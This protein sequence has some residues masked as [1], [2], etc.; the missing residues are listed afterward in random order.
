MGRWQR[1]DLQHGARQ[2]VRTGLETGFE[3]V[4]TRGG[5]SF[6]QSTGGSW[7]FVTLD[8]QL[9][10]PPGDY[11]L[12]ADYISESPDLLRIGTPSSPL[13]L[14]LH[15]YVTFDSSRQSST[16]ASGL[17]FP[18][19]VILGEVGRFGPN[20]LF[21]D[22]FSPWATIPEPATWLL[23]VLAAPALC[24]RRVTRTRSPARFR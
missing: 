4:Q 5:P 17:Q 18:D 16:W 7:I 24:L 14:D 12:G 23:G 15:P 22:N 1:R 9:T 8:E 10:I 2:C 3:G 11:V 13:T 19:Q 20:L 21:W 6:A